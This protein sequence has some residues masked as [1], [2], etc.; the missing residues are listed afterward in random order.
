MADILVVE[1]YPPMATLLTRLLR[2]R[3]HEVTRELA[4]A[5]A[6]RHVRAFDHA[7]LDIDLPDG[8]GVTLAQQLV[9]LRRVG[10]IIFFTATLE[11]DVLANA[12]R[13]GRVVGKAEGVNRLISAL[14]QLHEG[15]PMFD[16]NGVTPC[17]RLGLHCS[18]AASVIG[19]PTIDSP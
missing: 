18:A 6:M 1:D 14:E 12:A 9:R 19:G 8:N 13:L 3:G 10:S 17:T 7:I 2:S 16:E 4:V 15:A 11:P 5:A